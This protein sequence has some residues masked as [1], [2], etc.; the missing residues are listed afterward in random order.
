MRLFKISENTPTPLDQGDWGTS[1]VEHYIDIDDIVGLQIKYDVHYK[2][3]SRTD[4]WMVFRRN[5]GIDVTEAQY[6]RIKE[7]LADKFVE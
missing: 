4:T 1:V 5:G 3:K 6:N 7:L 2:D